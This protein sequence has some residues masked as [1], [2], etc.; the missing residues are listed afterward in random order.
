MEMPEDERARWTAEAEKL[1]DCY[2]RQQSQWVQSGRYPKTSVFEDLVFPTVPA[3]PPAETCDQH[4]PLISVV[5]L[6]S[7]IDTFTSTFA[8]ECSL[9]DSCV[10]QVVASFKNSF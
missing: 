6:E 4:I 5:Q 7:L 9:D 10:R 1:K 8:A 3:H 2:D